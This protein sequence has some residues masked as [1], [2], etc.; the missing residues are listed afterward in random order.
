MNLAQN[1]GIKKDGYQSR[2]F[3][4]IKQINSCNTC[5]IRLDAASYAS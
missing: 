3:N 5:R 4:D 1:E 2:L